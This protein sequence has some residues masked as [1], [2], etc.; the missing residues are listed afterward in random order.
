[1]KIGG[2]AYRNGLILFGENY[3]VKAYYEDGELLYQVGQNTLK[4]NKFFN[5]VQ[6]IPILRGI[7]KLLFSLYYFF[8]EAA[9]NPKRFWPILAILALDI[10]LEL[11][12]IFFPA[13]STQVVNQIFFL[14][15]L[16]YWGA[17]II[18][19]FVL[20]ETLLKEIFKFHGAEHKAVN[21]YQG[22]LSG[23]LNDYSRLARRCGTNLVAIYLFLVLVIESL[24]FGFNIFL[25][26]LLL[27]GVAYELLLIIPESILNIPYLVQKFTTVE[28]DEKHLKAA[29]T[30]L[31]LLLAYEEESEV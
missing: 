16:F 15:P 22:D 30:A 10:V 27:L 13:S 14:D 12:F 6:Q 4:D 5:F 9:G 11:Y 19:V 25:E 28:P 21:Y 7:F 18:G 17:L 3:S 20:R 26:T 1:M 29:Q 31:D 24:G 23:E 2:R 8:K